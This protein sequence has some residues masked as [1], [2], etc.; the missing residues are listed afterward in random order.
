MLLMVRAHAYVFPLPD[1]SSVEMMNMLF[2]T[3]LFYNELSSGTFD[4]FL[5]QSLYQ[6]F[7]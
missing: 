3:E 1:P 5:L 2:A 7:I 6:F 4:R